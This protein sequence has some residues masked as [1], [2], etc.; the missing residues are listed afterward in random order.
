MVKYNAWCILGCRDG[1]ISVC[2]SWCSV[3]L[4]V[5]LCLVHDIGMGVLLDLLVGV[6]MDVGMG[7]GWI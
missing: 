5:R 1:C 6:G 7:V 2:R 4:G 3:G